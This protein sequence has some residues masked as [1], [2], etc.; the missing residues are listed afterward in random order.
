MSLWDPIRGVSV[1][2]TGH[3]QIRPDHVSA[4]W[5]P[6]YWWLFTSPTGP[7]RGRSMPASS[8]PEPTDDPD[9]APFEECHDILGDGSLVLLPT[10]G[11]TPGPMSLLVCQSGLPSFMLVGDPTYDVHIPR[12][13]T[14]P[15]RRQPA[16]TA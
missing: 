3:V 10:P 7:R 11:H 8:E 6:T 13:R 16:P 1:V 14:C 9:L 15:R 2:S 5:R 12:G 4:T